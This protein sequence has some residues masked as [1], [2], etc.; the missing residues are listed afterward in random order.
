MRVITPSVGAAL[1]LSKGALINVVTLIF[2]SDVHE[3]EAGMALAD[4]APKRVDALP[5][6][7]AGDSSGRTFVNIHT[8]PPVRSQLQA[9]GRTLAP[10]LSFDHVTAVLT[11]GH[12]TC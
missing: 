3:V 2:A 5:K 4:V 6:S 10:D 1:V 7:R 11:V 8:G 12:G 9:R